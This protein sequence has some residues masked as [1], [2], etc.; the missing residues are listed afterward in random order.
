MLKQIAV[1]LAVL[2]L[3]LSV[4]LCACVKQPN[5]VDDTTDPTQSATLD[6]GTDDPPP[7]TTA[8][9]PTTTVVVPPQTT[10]VPDIGITIEPSPPEVLAPYN[11]LFGDYKSWYNQ[12]LTCEYD[13][14]K[15]IDLESLFYCGFD[16][17]KEPTDAEWEELKK[18]PWF[19]SY[20]Q[21]ADFNRLPDDEMNAV[22]ETYFGITLADVDDS[23]FDNLEYMECTDC[24]YHM[25]TDANM[26]EN[27]EAIAVEMQDD[28]SVRMYYRSDSHNGV[29]VATLIPNGDGFRIL[30]NLP[31]E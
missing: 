2:C 22:L 6:T 19:E 14:P 24:Y 30:S 27:F 4:M 15:Y 31:V 17:E 28:G 3:L 7:T 25:V 1:L 16:G 20:Y 21:Y 5:P 29:F 11:A 10:T 23:G 26:V 13:S 9:I 12:A 18:H 8:P